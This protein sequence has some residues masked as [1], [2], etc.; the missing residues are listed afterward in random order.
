MYSSYIITVYNLRKH[1]VVLMD[2]EH[3]K[4]RKNVHFNVAKT[5]VLGQFLL[6]FYKVMC[7]YPT[8]TCGI[9][10]AIYTPFDNSPY[11]FQTLR[12]F[13]MIFVGKEHLKLTNISGSCSPLAIWDWMLS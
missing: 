3:P 6:K 4:G 7:T 2:K 1:H 9:K 12:I 11:I 8:R 5:N 13:F 10:H